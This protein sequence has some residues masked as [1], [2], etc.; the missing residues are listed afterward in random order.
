MSPFKMNSKV[1]LEALAGFMCLLAATSGLAAGLLVPG[2]RPNI[3]IVMTDDLD[4]VLLETAVSA[5]FMPILEQTFIDAGVRMN[6][7]FVSNSLFCPS[8][9][10]FLT[11]QYTHNHGV[12]TNH[13]PY[14]F[15][16]LD[17]SSILATWLTDAGYLTGFVGKYLNGFTHVI[18]CLFQ[19]GLFIE[20]YVAGG[21]KNG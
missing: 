3:V 7:S 19:H 1:W 9:A 17:D 10:T 13:K 6:N 21:G 2:S 4:E 11:G 8:R 15:D 12:L 14:R 20:V 16:A 18:G 5:G